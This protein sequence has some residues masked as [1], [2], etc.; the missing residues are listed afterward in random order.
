M[1]TLDQAV[2]DIVCPID[3]VAA[4]QAIPTVTIQTRPRRTDDAA[5]VLFSGLAN[6]AGQD[7]ARALGCI[8]T[9]VKSAEEYSAQIEHVYRGL[10]DS[11]ETEEPTG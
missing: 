8:V 10:G 6:S 4:L 9:V 11:P 2:V 7:A 5:R 3:Q 1:P